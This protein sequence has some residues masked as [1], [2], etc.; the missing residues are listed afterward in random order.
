MIN[1][2]KSLTIIQRL[3]AAER[4]YRKHDPRFA[5]GLKHAIQICAADGWKH[6]APAWHRKETK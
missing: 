5:D 6:I 4:Y 1:D 3:K 2:T